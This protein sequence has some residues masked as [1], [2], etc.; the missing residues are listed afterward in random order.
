ML[1]A[2]RVS[3]FILEKG[4]KVKNGLYESSPPFPICESDLQV[5]LGC[6]SM[7]GEG[8]KSPPLPSGTGSPAIGGGGGESITL[9]LAG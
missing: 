2:A 9:V 3:F 4:A 7:E 8:Y 6:S 5:L 1:F